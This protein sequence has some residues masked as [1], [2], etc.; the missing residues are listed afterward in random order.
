MRER[1]AIT[2][3]AYR[4]V[5]IVALAALSVIVLTGAAVR[6][7]GSGLGCPDWPKCY[8]K[9]FAPLETHAVIEYGNRIISG[10]VGL[11]AV[12]AGLLAWFR[13][14]F[15]RDLALL[16]AVLPIGVISQAVLGG[17]TVRHHLAPGFVMGHFALSMLILVAA[18]ALAWC[19][20]FEPGERPRSTDRLSVWAVRALLPLGALTI[21]AGTAATAAGPHAGGQGSQRI[22]R[23]EFKGHGTLNWAIHQHARIAALLGRRR[24]RRVVPAAPPR[25]RPGSAARRDRP[26]GPPRRPG[27]GG[28]PAV[29]DEAAG[30]DRLGPRRAGRGH[31]AH[32][33]VVDRR[34]GAA[35]RQP[36]SRRVTRPSARIGQP[37]GVSLITR[38]SVS[39]R[40]PKRSRAALPGS[41]S[42]AKPTSTVAR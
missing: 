28:H 21:F 15:R 3:D 32:G 34:G 5:T 4:R 35:G 19:A 14:P 1:F 17:F 8:G 30:R 42:A 26:R 38:R 18:V 27:R 12:A 39:L 13:R 41:G 2:P 36:R 7:T 9:A 31:V 20:S 23:L 37:S 33:A 25:R 29:R 10:F 40:R 24:G 11:A 16:G 22:N 6:L